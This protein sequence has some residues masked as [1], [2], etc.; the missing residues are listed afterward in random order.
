[1]TSSTIEVTRDGPV[2]WLVFDRPDRGNAI[3]ATMF[4]EL[5]AAWA[6][7]DADP[8][9][10]VIVNTGNGSSFQ[11]GLDV[12][13]LASNREALREHS[14]RTRDFELRMTAWHCQVWKPVVAAVNGVCAGGGLHFVAD[15]DIVIAAAGATFLDPHVSV[16]QV[17]AIET[18]GMVR[19]SPMEPI[20]RMAL[21]GRHER[22]SASRAYE[23]GIISEIVDPAEGLRERAQ[24]I[25]ETIARNSPAAM[26]ATKR[27]LWGALEHGLTDACRAGAE[28]LVGM[29]DHPDH[30]VRRLT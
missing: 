4:T 23:L 17:S 27:A 5:E 8:A 30:G 28:E 19:R 14:R 12:R 3:D 15:A 7:L 26:A 9:V 11:T 24:E 10:R 16:G 18:I 29:W 21:V 6:E 25:G 13:E 22:M 1:M 2:G 20:V